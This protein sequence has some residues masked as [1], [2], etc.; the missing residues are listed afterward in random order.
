MLPVALQRKGRRRLCVGAATGATRRGAAAPPLP[1]AAA[2]PGFLLLLLL[3]LAAPL[4]LPILAFLAI[5]QPQSQ[6]K[7]AAVRVADPK[8][9]AV[10]IATRRALRA[11]HRQH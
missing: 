10:A 4:L 9:V 11:G 5:A 3:L 8:L 2:L 7:F 1:A 6:R